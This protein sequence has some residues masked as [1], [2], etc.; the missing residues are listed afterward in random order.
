MLFIKY[1]YKRFPDLRF[2]VKNYIIIYQDL[3][4]NLYHN[5]RENHNN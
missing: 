1:I 4:I 5:Q 3:D 2:K